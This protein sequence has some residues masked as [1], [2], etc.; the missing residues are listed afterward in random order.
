MN[1]IIKNF[2]RLKQTFESAKQT[3]EEALSG[4]YNKDFVKKFGP[5]ALME[6]INYNID[7][8]ESNLTTFVKN[9]PII[10]FH[11]EH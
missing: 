2:N 11:V 3:K 7:V 6:D 1:T 5:R 9:N 8:A 10:M 4:N